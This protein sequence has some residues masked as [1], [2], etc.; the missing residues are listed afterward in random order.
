MNFYFILNCFGNYE[1]VTRGFFD[2][3]IKNFSSQSINMYDT[4][5]YTFYFYEGVLLCFIYRKR[6]A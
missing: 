6:G 3:F 5:F 4:H 1:N 2:Q